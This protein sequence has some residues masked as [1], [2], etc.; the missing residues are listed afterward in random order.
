MY[1]SACVY[2]YVTRKESNN[3]KVFLTLRNIPGTE[4]MNMIFL[5][6][7]TRYEARGYVLVYIDVDEDEVLPAG[8]VWYIKIPDLEVF[9]RCYTSRS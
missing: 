1:I 5:Q 2:R 7:Y 8:I 9:G 4:Y 6:V 3:K